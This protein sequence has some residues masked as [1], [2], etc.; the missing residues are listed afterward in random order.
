MCF[1]VGLDGLGWASADVPYLACLCGTGDPRSGNSC[2][3]VTFGTAA[4]VP[5][6]IIMGLAPIRHYIRWVANVQR[7]RVW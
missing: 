6:I 5:D 7:E 2:R 3:T 1:D 4:A